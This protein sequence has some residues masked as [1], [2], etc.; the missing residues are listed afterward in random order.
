MSYKGHHA[1]K[2]DE[3]KRK[4]WQDPEVILRM[5]GIEPGMTFVDIGCGS[6]YFT[7]PAARMV[8]DSGKVYSLDVDPDAINALKTKALGAGLKNI[9]AVVGSGEDT[10]LCDACADII[11]FGNVLHD[12]ENAVTVL[13]NARKMVAA[14]GHLYDIDWKAEEMEFG[15]PLR[16][17]FSTEYASELI[18]AASFHVERIADATDYHYLIEAVPV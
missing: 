17:R 6:G 7:L 4:K 5:L 18:A 8:G 11:F 15:P 16:M 13:S 12:F 9:R 2:Y 10:V 1:W 3:E 14:S